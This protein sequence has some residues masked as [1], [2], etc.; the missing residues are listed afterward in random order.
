MIHFIRYAERLEI[1]LNLY[2]APRGFVAIWCWF[3]MGSLTVTH[4]RL[5]VSFTKFPVMRWSV[6]SFDMISN[7]LETRGLEL[8]NQEVLQDLKT[9][10]D[11][12]KRLNELACHIRPG[13]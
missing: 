9:M 2:R 6:S 10:E 12:Q 8:V 3:N 7:Y 5:R 4:R 1:G 11:T 13:A